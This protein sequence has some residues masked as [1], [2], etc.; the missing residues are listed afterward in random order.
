MPDVSST[1]PEQVRLWVALDVHKFSIVAAA[2]PPAGAAPE[3]LQI[4]TTEAAI[5][6]F[7]A[8]LGGP[9]GLA[10]CYETQ[11]ILLHRDETRQRFE[12]QALDPGR[13][14][15]CDRRRHRSRRRRRRRGHS[16][17]GPAADAAPSRNVA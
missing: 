6:P 1:A 17:S 12:Y 9:E 5:R 3:L 8:R 4:E 13:R 11:P 16:R 14:R 15:C 2:L 10:V 7:I